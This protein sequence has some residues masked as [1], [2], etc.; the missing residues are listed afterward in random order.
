M[1][2]NAQKFAARRASTASEVMQINNKPVCTDGDHM[3]EGEGERGVVPLS[4]RSHSPVSTDCTTENAVRCS[5]MSARVSAEFSGFSA[6]CG[7]GVEYGAEFSAF[8]AGCG[9]GVEY[10][11]GGNGG[12]RGGGVDGGSAGIG[13]IAGG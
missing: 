1:H 10:G 11:T 6:G 2:E 4:A 9:C 5:W 13:G 3:R 12:A 7:C 8:G